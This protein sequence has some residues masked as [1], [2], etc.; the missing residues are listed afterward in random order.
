MSNYTVK[1]AVQTRHDTNEYINLSEISSEQRLSIIEKAETRR[2]SLLNFWTEDPFIEQLQKQFGAQILIP[3]RK[4]HMIV[5][6]GA[7]D[8]NN[9]KLIADM[10]KFFE[11]DVVIHDWDGKEEIEDTRK[12]LI[13][14]DIKPPHL[15]P[16]NA[17][18]LE[19]AMGL[20]EA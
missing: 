17:L 13:F 8:K 1:P 16:Y 20:L 11:I 12:T 18:S 19:G 4:K 9:K 7:I 3:M 14:T 2:P 10:K 15:Q 6:Y 5:I